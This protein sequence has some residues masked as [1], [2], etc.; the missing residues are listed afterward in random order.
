MTDTTDV[1]GG[2]TILIVEDHARM[3]RNLCEFLHSA[4]P[5]CILR[6]AMDAASALESCQVFGPD[7]VLMDKCLPDA[8]G[9]E[10]TLRLR[11]LHAGIKIIVISY[12]SEAIYTERA[13]A[14]GAL[15]Y[16]FK[17]RIFTDLAPAIAAALGITPPADSGNIQ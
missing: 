5:H 6:E 13:V 7:L 4:F 11:T 8:D 16:V 9:I 15:G 14:A 2:K 17:D 10:L 12:R 3:R 1:G